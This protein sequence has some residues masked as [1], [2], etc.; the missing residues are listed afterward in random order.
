MPLLPGESRESDTY[1]SGLAFLDSA[2]SQIK[3]WANK[4]QATI[5][6][7][8]A[9]VTAPAADVRRAPSLE[10]AQGPMVPARQYIDEDII[11]RILTRLV[12]TVLF[13]MHGRWES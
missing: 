8:W 2:A 3:S 9:G 7:T 12:V 11:L 10:I 13:L 5:E 4:T 1:V 6:S